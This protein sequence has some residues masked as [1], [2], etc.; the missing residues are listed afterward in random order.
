[1]S[2]P[3]TPPGLALVEGVEQTG[4]R[5]EAPG[6]V[7]VLLEMRTLTELAVALGDVDVAPC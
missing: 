5:R 3:G 7:S 1:M 2:A 6:R 4:R